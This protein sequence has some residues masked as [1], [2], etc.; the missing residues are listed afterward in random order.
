MDGGLLFGSVLRSAITCSCVN[1]WS[2]RSGGV[3]VVS[4]SQCTK[5]GLVEIPAEYAE[6]SSKG[7]EIVALTA[8]ESVVSK[9]ANTRPER[10][11]LTQSGRTTFLIAAAQ[12]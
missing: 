11:M 5:R 1:C 10:L 4:A 8:D 3:R 12:D 6:A 9:T 7:R 2:W